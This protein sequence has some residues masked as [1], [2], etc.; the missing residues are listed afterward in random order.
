MRIDSL[1]A[2]EWVATLGPSDERD[3]AV[4]SL[5]TRIERTDL[6]A[7]FVWADTIAD[8]RRRDETMRRLNR[9]LEERG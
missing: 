2:S 6:D 4:G 3:S 8:E 9:R 5:I 1:A 7:A